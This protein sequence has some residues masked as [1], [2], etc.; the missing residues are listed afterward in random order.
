MTTFK[1]WGSKR[2]DG[3]LFISKPKFCRF[4]LFIQFYNGNCDYPSYDYRKK[5]KFGIE[6]ILKSELSGF[7]KLLESVHK[8]T[9][10]GID[11]RYANI[12]ANLSH[13][14]NYTTGNYNYLVCTL[15]PRTFNWKDPLYWKPGNDN[16][17]LDIPK[18]RAYAI[19]KNNEEES[20]R[21]RIEREK[22]FKQIILPI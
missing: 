20:E 13:D 7:T 2:I 14:L 16:N 12:F 1:K 4:K 19:A 5:Y 18:M 8:K 22:M 6:H 9:K 15:T 11:Y 17:M 10:H 3:K 21:I